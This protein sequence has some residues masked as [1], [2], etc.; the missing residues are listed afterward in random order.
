[1]GKATKN[2]LVILSCVLVFLI[3]TVTVCMVSC[4]K[5]KQ[6]ETVTINNYDITVPENADTYRYAAMKAIGSAVHIKAT[7][8]GN[9]NLNSKRTIIILSS[10]TIITSDGY[11]LTNSHS[12]SYIGYR[13]DT[14]NITTF[15]QDY[16]ETSYTAELVS[17][18][19]THTLD[20]AVLKISNAG[21]RSFMP[22]TISSSD[23]LKMGEKAFMLGESAGS[24]FMLSDAVIAHPKATELAYLEEGF[25]ELVKINANVNQGKSV[26]NANTALFRTGYYAYIGGGSGLYNIKGNFIGMVTYRKAGEDSNAENLVMGIGYA[27][28]AE[29]IQAVL[30]KNYSGIGLKWTEK[31]SIE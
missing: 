6:G 13:L 12:V 23:E 10:G 16:N 8:K 27:I 7:L 24:G 17:A 22:A 28:R 31:E 18:N 5:P 9:N 15:D 20:L 3:I 21:N 30:T 26:T 19:E 11:L 14:L 2:R 25:S 1:M 4:V 29:D